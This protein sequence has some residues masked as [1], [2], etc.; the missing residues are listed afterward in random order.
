MADWNTGPSDGG[1]GTAGGSQYA[2]ASPNNGNEEDWGGRND[3]RDGTDT[4]CNGC[5]QGE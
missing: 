4:L 5:G 1:W 3:L 2:S